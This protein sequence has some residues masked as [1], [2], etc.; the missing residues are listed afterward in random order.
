[1]KKILVF[2]EPE[3][4]SFINA[5]VGDRCEIVWV[6]KDE[7]LCSRFQQEQPDMVLMNYEVSDCSRYAR[8][9]EGIRTKSAKVPIILMSGQDIM[10]HIP[11]NVNGTLFKPFQKEFLE[12][13]LQKYN[14]L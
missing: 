1:M 7:E 4:V 6:S 8:L 13:M 14:I 9:L 12:N 11:V 2:D 5:A 10:S 3:V